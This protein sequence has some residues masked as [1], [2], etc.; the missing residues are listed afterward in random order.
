[1]F[2]RRESLFDGVKRRA[3][4][5]I[6]CTENPGISAYG[7]VSFSLSRN[8]GDRWI[9]SECVRATISHLSRSF[10]VYVCVCV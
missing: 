2:V 1:V 3:R 5:C 9:V 7:S 10:S 8:Q 4:A 6:M